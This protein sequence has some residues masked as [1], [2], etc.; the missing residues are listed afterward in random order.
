MLLQPLVLPLQDGSCTTK[1]LILSPLLVCNIHV[2]SVHELQS[3]AVVRHPHKPAHVEILQCG[4]QKSTDT[5]HGNAEYLTSSLLH[6]SGTVTFG[7]FYHT[8]IEEM[9][10][11]IAD[12]I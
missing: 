2:Q 7:R 11:D 8:Q 1:S 9:P 3:L 5:C 4:E 12:L 6:L 10:M